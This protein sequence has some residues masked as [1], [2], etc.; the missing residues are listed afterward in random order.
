M[1]S[2]ARS[3]PRT[4]I[5]ARRRR[6]AERFLYAARDLRPANEQDLE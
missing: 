4:S 1:I 2:I 5:D 6:C 3:P